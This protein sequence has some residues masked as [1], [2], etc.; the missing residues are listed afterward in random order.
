ML[1]IGLASD[2]AKPT[3]KHC[4][5]LHDGLT[6]FAKIFGIEMY[7]KPRWVVLIGLAAVFGGTRAQTRFEKGDETGVHQKPR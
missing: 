4:Q 2:V 3:A 5:T 6:Q 1:R 7:L